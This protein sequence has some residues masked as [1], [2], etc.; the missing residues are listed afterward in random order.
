ME[1]SP[2]ITTSC[3]AVP[4][5]DVPKAVSH[6]AVSSTFLDETL[7][8]PVHPTRTAERPEC[9]D[10]YAYA[11][12][13]VAMLVLAAAERYLAA[14]LLTKAANNGSWL[15]L[16]TFVFL[17]D[18][19]PTLLSILL[20][21]DIQEFHPLLSPL[22]F[23]RAMLQLFHF[24]VNWIVAFF[25]VRSCYRFSR[26]AGHVAC[27]AGAILMLGVWFVLLPA[28]GAPLPGARKA[29]KEPPRQVRRPFDKT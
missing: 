5:A 18:R 27:V 8:A 19:Q 15:A 3:N 6:A 2:E 24:G 11:P 21:F 22:T 4:S 7:S 10:D 29:E 9:R 28:L 13:F 1:E 20:G 25:L 14:C 23:V 16:E 26:I 17:F 12:A